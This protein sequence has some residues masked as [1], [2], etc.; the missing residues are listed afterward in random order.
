MYYIKVYNR[1]EFIGFFFHLY[2]TKN[3]L[4]EAINA[5]FGVEWTNYS[6]ERF[7]NE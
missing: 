4:I 1:G 5:N 3:G 7:E 6:M 2:K